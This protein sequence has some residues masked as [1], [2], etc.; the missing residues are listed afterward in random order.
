MVV[1]LA[2]W[3]IAILFPVL[4]ESPLVAVAPDIM[5]KLSFPVATALF[6]GLSP[7]AIAPPIVALASAP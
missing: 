5:A 6:D 1:A 2:L 4:V 7:I 3:P